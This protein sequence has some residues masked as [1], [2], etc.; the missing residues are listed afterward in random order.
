MASLVTFFC[1]SDMFCD[2]FEVRALHHIPSMRIKKC[3]HTREN[4]TNAEL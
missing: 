1:P 3:T 2:N 4:P